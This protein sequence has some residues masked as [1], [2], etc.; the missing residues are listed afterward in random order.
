MKVSL[1]SSYIEFH[2]HKLKL[3][4]LLY[5]IEYNAHLNFTM[6]FGKK[7]ILFFKN[8][9]TRINHC[10]FIHHRSHHKTF[11]SYLPC[12]VHR[13]YFSIIFHVKKCT[14]NMINYGKFARLS[15]LGQIRNLKHARL[16]YSACKRMYKA[17]AVFKTLHFLRSLRIG[18]IS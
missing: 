3:G 5:F 13:E 16:R 11:L 8:N 1:G 9:F 14:Q 12:I 10:K 17:L 7:M 2:T 15:K 4:H 18:P 6:I